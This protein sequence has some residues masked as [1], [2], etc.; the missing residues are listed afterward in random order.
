MYMVFMPQT[1]PHCG[2]EINGGGYPMSLY[3]W[4]AT[5]VCITGMVVNVWRS[6]W[7]FIFWIVVKIMWA[8]FD[9]QQ[10]LFSRLALDGL[11]LFL[12][13][14]GALKNPVWRRVG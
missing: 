7:C 13:I 12:A 3:C 11:G 8:V 1:L 4:I 5:A 10:G 6:N 9:I 14:V 2:V